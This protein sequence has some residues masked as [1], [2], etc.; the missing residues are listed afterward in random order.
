MCVT[1]KNLVIN[2][3]I[4]MDNENEQ[5]GSFGLLPILPKE[6]PWNGFDFS[7]VNIGLAIATWCF[8]IGGTLSFFVDFKMGIAATLAGNTIGVIIMALS[9]TSPS[10][11]Y[12]IDQY[13]SLRSVFGYKGTKIPVFL[14]LI[15]EFGWV[16][17]LAIMFGKASYNI[18]GSFFNI[19]NQTLFV[20]IFA[21]IAIIATWIIVAKGPVSIKWF[22]RIVA[23]AL[24]VLLIVMLV[25]LMKNFTIAELFAFQP[26]DPGPSRWWN[27][28]IAFELG[29]V[30]GLSWWPVMGGLSRLAKTQR[31]AFW[32]NMVGVNLLAF[33]GTM[34]GLLA[35]L[36]LGTNDPTEWMIPLVGP[37][38][39]VFALLFVAFGNI[40]SMSSLVYSTSI[41]LKQVDFFSNM[42]WERQTFL[43]MVCIVPFVL[44]PEQVYTNFSTFLVFCGVAFGPLAGI[45]IVDYFVLRKQKLDLRNLY[46]NGNVN[47]YKFWNGY[48]LSAVISLVLG[49]II[50]LVLLNPL[51]FSNHFLF[52]IFSASLPSALVGGGLHY[53]I[54][55]FFIIPRRL[56]DYQEQQEELK[57]NAI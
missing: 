34:I 35:G 42:K 33:V 41:A 13:V 18:L 46:T 2:G 43:F 8:L 32:P 6:R 39:G 52:L 40:T 17:I 56:G 53:F 48:N 4:F 45:Y 24:V 29:L 51:T 3:G 5:S 31:A 54:T 27:Y 26:L 30:S 19:S 15:V 55:R 47:K 22:N 50:Y 11:K 21:I 57:K 12:G 37:V 14:I 7:M 23:P 28:M 16:S 1:T 49:I 10:S 36:S 25:V 38:L 9:T 20:S 44:F